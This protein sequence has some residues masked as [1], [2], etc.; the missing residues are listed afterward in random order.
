[1]LG[2]VVAYADQTKERLLGVDSEL[3]AAHGAVSP[4]VADAMADGALARF[5]ADL[6]SRSPAWPGPAAGRRRSRWA[7]CAGR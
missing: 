2:S 7:T 3:I 6:L 1:M 5:D 4:Q